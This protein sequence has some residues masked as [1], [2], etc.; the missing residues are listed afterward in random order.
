MDD[1]ARV[2]TTLGIKTSATDSI[3]A[4]HAQLRLL[5]DGAKAI[6]IIDV[7]KSALLRMHLGYLH[8]PDEHLPWTGDGATLPLT[9]PP[10]L[11]H[12]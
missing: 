2:G 3:K 7:S 4:I 1:A 8:A 5:T 10:L 9:A 12:H 6:D 11:R